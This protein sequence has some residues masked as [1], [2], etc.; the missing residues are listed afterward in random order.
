MAIAEG[1]LASAEKPYSLLT[2]FGNT[3][4]D[5]SGLAR[6]PLREAFARP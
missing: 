5:S 6:D 1:I 3:T 4:S 2:L